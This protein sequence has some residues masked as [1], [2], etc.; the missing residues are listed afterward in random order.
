MAHRSRASTIAGGTHQL[1]H[2][3]LEDA[4]DVV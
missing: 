2:R 4:Q 1:F 3:L